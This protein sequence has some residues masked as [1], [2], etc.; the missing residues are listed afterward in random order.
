M[1]S[2]YIGDEVGILVQEGGSRVGGTSLHEGNCPFV[3]AIP[4]NFRPMF[5][6]ISV[7]IQCGGGLFRIKFDSMEI[8]TNVLDD[9]FWFHFQRIQ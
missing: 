3:D 9:F 2:R 5:I 4:S 8:I 6:G 1:K 7:N